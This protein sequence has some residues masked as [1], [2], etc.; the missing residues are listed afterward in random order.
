MAESAA[1]K[2][3]TL[4]MKII[5]GWGAAERKQMQEGLPALSLFS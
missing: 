2:Y 1:L 5:W 3:T 4:G